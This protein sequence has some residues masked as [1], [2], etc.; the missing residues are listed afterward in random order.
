MTKEEK[1]TSVA[2]YLAKVVDYL[3][4]VSDEPTYRPLRR[5][6]THGSTSI[7]LSANIQVKN[8][9]P[10]LATGV[11]SLEVGEKRESETVG[12]DEVAGTSD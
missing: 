7:S 8:L 12:P 1:F 6:N 5:P 9:L 10:G 4:G 3:Q 11:A 2:I